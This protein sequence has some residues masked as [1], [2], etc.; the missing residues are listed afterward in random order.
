M[1]TGEHKV[2]SN[3]FKAQVEKEAGKDQV[4]S[5][6]R[7][8]QAIGLVCA[9]IFLVFFVIHQTRPT[10]FFTDDFGTGDAALLYALILSGM[11]SPIVRLI[12]GRK[13][14]ARPFDAGGMAFVFIGGLYF[15]VT[16]P[17]DFTY[18][19]APLPHVLEPLI[20]WVSGTFARWLLGIG[21][22]ASPFFSAYN[23]IL[24]F[25]VRKHFAET[26]ADSK[27]QNPQ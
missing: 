14:I 20:D 1:E 6:D 26:S 18:F 7:I 11:L 16:F 2:G 27:V 19:A 15:L 5:T 10:G 22:V 9:A 24:Y 21:V 25:G 8:G 12:Y 3:W 13:N 23:F 4:P 17:F